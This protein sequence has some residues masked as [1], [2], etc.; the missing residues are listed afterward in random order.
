MNNTLQAHMH[1]RMDMI[2]A[3]NVCTLNHN[4]MAMITE[5]IANKE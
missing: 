1:M 3:T 2:A 4:H 5:H